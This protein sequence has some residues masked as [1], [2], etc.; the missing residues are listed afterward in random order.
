MH[1]IHILHKGIHT[2]YG[3]S[4]RNTTGSLLPRVPVEKTAIPQVLL[5]AL[6]WMMMLF[7]V[8]RM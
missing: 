7:I 2:Y 3:E 5:S 4:R 1:I 6:W 8:V